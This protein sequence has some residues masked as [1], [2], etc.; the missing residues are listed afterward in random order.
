MTKKLKIDWKI[1]EIDQNE[2]KMTKKWIFWFAKK[3]VLL[4]NCFFGLS[5]VIWPLKPYYQLR[6]PYF[7]IEFHNGCLSLLSKSLSI[8]SIN[9]LLPKPE[10]FKYM[11]IYV[12]PRSVWN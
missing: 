11:K 3:R 4:F 2:S 10:D 1:A 5:I 7:V 8:I 12:K 6:N 9:M